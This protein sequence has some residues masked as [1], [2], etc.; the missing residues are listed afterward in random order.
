M[1]RNF[2]QDF[3]GYELEYA[4]GEPWQGTMISLG[5]TKSYT[6]KVGV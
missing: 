6:M 5:M 2:S 1:N 4:L 3:F